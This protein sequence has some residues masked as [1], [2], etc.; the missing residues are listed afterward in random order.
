MFSSGMPLLYIIVAIN[1]TV[2]FWID[3]W[4]LLRFYTIPTNFNGES[5]LYSVSLMKYGIVFHFILGYFLISEHSILESEN[6]N[7][8]EHGH[9]AHLE[10]YYLYIAVVTFIVN[11]LTV[12][13]WRKDGYKCIQNFFKRKDKTSEEEVISNNYYDEINL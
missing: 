6:H 9:P 12:L 1:F 13:F 11:L 2:T 5:I 8:D 7:P 4:L 3:K 10:K